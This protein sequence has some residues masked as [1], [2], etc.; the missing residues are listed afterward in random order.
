MKT[1]FEPL[2]PNPNPTLGITPLVWVVILIKALYGQLVSLT[3]KYSDNIVKLFAT[4]FSATAS[5]L[6]S[7]IYWGTPLG[8]ALM[9][10]TLVA[11]SAIMFQTGGSLGV[12]LMLSDNQLVSKTQDRLRPSYFRKMQQRWLLLAA[13]ISVLGMGAY[14][15]WG[16]AMTAHGHQLIPAHGN[17]YPRPNPSN[18]NPDPNS[19]TP[20]N[21]NPNLQRNTEGEVGSEYGYKSQALWGVDKVGSSNAT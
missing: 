14:V 15:L 7:W 16:P 13:G 2:N 17:A 21:R 19:P 6:F 18:P 5:A 8:T 12:F 4:S 11:L 3:L 9:S 10:G 1:G 20:L